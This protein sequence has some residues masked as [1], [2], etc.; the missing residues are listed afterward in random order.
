MNYPVFDLHCDTALEL[1]GKDLKPKASL[2]KNNGHIDL[3]RGKTLPGYAQCFAM[4]TFP[5]FEKWFEKP[6]PMVF[7]AMVANLMKELEANSDAIA[8]AGSTDDI[9]RN[10]EA[11]KMSAILT[12]APACGLSLEDLTEML[13]LLS[14]DTL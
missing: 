6:V 14:D 4:F 3:T 2:L 10:A 7:E 1:I 8:P 9:H 5:G 12:L 11:G 13:K